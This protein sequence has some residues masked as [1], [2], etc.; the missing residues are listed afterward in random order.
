MTWQSRARAGGSSQG[1]AM[2]CHAVP[3]HAM[4]CHAVPCRAMPC[5]AV[6]CRAVPCHAMPCHA[7]PHR[8]MP[9][10]A[11]PCHAFFASGYARL[12]VA[13]TAT[14]QRRGEDVNMQLCPAGLQAA[15]WAAGCH[16]GALPLV[17]DGAV[18]ILRGA[19]SHTHPAM[20]HDASPVPV[21]HPPYTPTPFLHLPLHPPTLS[22]P[23][24]LRPPYTPCL[25]P[26]ALSLPVH[27]N[28]GL[29]LLHHLLQP[30]YLL[31]GLRS[32][33]H[34][35]RGYHPGGTTQGPEAHRGGKQEGTS[36][37]ASIRL[38]SSDSLVRRP[39]PWERFGVIIRTHVHGV[40]LHGTGPVHRA[41]P[42]W[43]YTQR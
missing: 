1:H 34:P 42:N 21:L 30:R 7:V 31:L 19:P 10:P 39:V 28:L 16:L 18:L 40:P 2:L 17:V 9:R 37:A 23:T 25:P 8:A 20:P 24:P 26:P 33:L 43:P 35:A 12:M 13:G 22:L 3:C 41:L 38:C 36:N 11:G 32:I 15:G 14:P 5:H 6:P 29:Q 27:L 4:P